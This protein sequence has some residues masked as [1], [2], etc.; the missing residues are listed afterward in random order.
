M[1]IAVIGTGYVGLVTGTCFAS[2]GHKVTCVDV[3]PEKVEKIN[4]GIPPIYE[5]DLDRMLKEVVEKGNLKA[6]LNL[7]EAVAKS[8]IIYICVGTPSL[9]DGSMDYIYVKEAAKGIARELTE[10]DEFK[11]I[12]VKSTC[13]PGTTDEIGKTII[14]KES[15]KK[16]N[17]DFGLGMNPEFLR[18]G[19]AIND[20]LYPDRIVIGGS[21]RETQNIIAKCYDEFNAP[22][23]FTDNT[24]A[25][26]IKYASNSF[27]A[28]KISFINEMANLAEKFGIDIKDVA[29]GVGMDHRI[30]GKFL[31]AGAGF[32]GSCFPKDVSALYVRSKELDQPSMLLEATLAVNKKQ[33]LRL[34]DLLK[35]GLES[36]D[37]KGKT[38]GLLGLAF[39]PDT[40]DMREAP[41]LILINKLLEEGV[42]IK[43]TDPVALENAKKEIAHEKLIYCE[44]MEDAVKETDAVI[45]ITEWKEF[46]DLSAE[47]F[48][49][50]M[51]NPVVIDGRRAFD[52]KEFREKGVKILAIG[53]GK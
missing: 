41:S 15:G 44:N 43:A 5:K 47:F 45:L 21:N 35:K 19:V 13:V 42:T 53:L 37:I 25:E 46:R 1:N 8:E 24:A 16:L 9:P 27:L 38:I 23:L 26:M 7:S 17:V 50:K 10:A 49:Q 22:I 33:P 29:K 11:V 3:I 39:K 30:S 34:I 12:V 14:E 20:F 40:D 52:Y 2:R 18:E 6:T 31:R 51:K 48:I 28:M 4:K 36:E 32:G